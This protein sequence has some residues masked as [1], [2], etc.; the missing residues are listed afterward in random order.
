MSYTTSK[1]SVVKIMSYCPV[2][3][4]ICTGQHAYRG[5]ILEGVKAM[6]DEMSSNSPPI[7]INREMA[8]RIV[9]SAKKTINYNINIMNENGI[10]IASSNPMRVGSFHEI[11]YQVINGPHDL[12]EINNA[13]E[14][15]GTR[16]GT[17]T[18]LK[19]KDYKVGVLGITGNPDEI[20]PFV[21]VL[22]LAVETM[23][24]FEMQQQDYI[25][26]TSQ[27]NLFDGGL[28]YGSATDVDLVRW[29]T[30]LKIDRAIYRIPLW[31]NVDSNISV[32]YKSMLLEALMKNKHYSVQDIM[33]QW[34]DNGLV[35]FKSFANIKQAYASFRDNIF[36]FLEDFIGQLEAAGLH[37]R[38][39]TGSFCKALGRYHEAYKRALWIYE[40][41]HQTDNKIEHFYDHIG[42]WMKSLI[43]AKELHDIYRFFATE[44]DEKYI[45]QMINTEEALSSSNYNFERASQKLYVHK[46]TLFLWMNNFRKLY[47]I[48]PVQN[49]YDRSFWSY[50][51]Y[52]LKSKPPQT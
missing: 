19:Y 52:Y 30:E 49:P 51:C 50:L 15:I 33:T 36:E 46:N 3:C 22:K 39:F 35:I 14:L 29:A 31:I 45:E 1:D 25:Q 2:Y 27:K 4:Q 47:N 5:S 21:S 42:K 13:D 20:R 12:Q 26:R 38:V 24:E 8:N 48:D 23:I 9:D 28:M 17:N 40:H 32:S 34:K 37:V 16:S 41:C 7:T 10:V 6:R 44:C 11:A 18:V 43:P